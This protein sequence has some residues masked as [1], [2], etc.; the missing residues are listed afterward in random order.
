MVLAHRLAQSGERVTL[1]EGAPGLGG[2]AGAWE[3]GD[4]VWDRHYHVTLRSDARLRALLG[5]VGLEEEI[6]WVETRSGCHLDGTIHPVS[7]VV[8][9]LR[10]R[11]LRVLD[12]LRLGA[13]IAYAAAIR[14]GRRLEAIPVAEW[15][16]R[17]SGRRAF[18]RLWRPLLR[19]KLG[20][21]YVETSAAFI[22]TVIQRL[23]RARR[24]GLQKEM[25]GYVP[26][27]YGRIIDRVAAL[28]AGEGVTVEVGKP[29]E[30][31]HRRGG[32]LVVR[33]GD[34]DERSFDKVVVTVSPPLAAE[35][36]AALSPQERAQLVS[37]AYVGIV[38]ASLLLGRPLSDRYLTYL[39]DEAPFSA[40]VEMSALVD[41]DQLGGHSLVYLPRYVAPG[42]P[43][44][45][46]SSE[47]I[48]ELFL[49]GL[50]KV[51][52]TFR[53][54]D[55][56]AFRLSRVRDVFALPALHLSQRVPP[57]PTSVPGLYLVNSAQI[58]NGTLN[59]NETIELAERASATLL[60][61]ERSLS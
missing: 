32:K 48:E 40:V 49:D 45:A 51:V 59:V 20:T 31:V 4:I 61:R 23:F 37:I 25:F 39:A 9:F 19:A 42:D 33:T 5:E 1:I 50:A 13:T 41:P 60:E 36:C 17:W 8:D 2:L 11:P 35:L 53:R 34:G 56:L 29:V 12:R 55:V 10:F 46:S 58:V 52:P 18:D 43:F 30:A 57:A 22:W 47:E 16:T 26:G 28:L 38:C 54:D 14:D 15:L 3:L 24:T 6:R 7:N 21:A 27:G 44:L